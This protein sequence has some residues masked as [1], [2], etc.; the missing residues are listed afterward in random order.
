MLETL[1]F[2]QGAVAKKDFVPALVHFHIE[3]GF[4]KGFNGKLGLCSPID[5]DLTVSPKAVPFIKAIQTC[6]ETV[7]MYM[8]GNGRLGIKSGKF[9][10]FIDC[11]E[12]TFPDIKP[13]GETKITPT[14]ELLPA[15]KKIAPFIAEDASRPWARGILFCNQSAFATNN[16]VLIEYWLGYDFPKPINIPQS[17]IQELIRINKEPSCIQISDTSL[18][19]HFDDKRWLKTQLFSTDWPDPYRI[20]EL[21]SNL[22]DIP[23]GLFEAVEDITPFVNELGAVYLQTNIVSTSLDLDNGATADVDGLPELAIYNNKH[24]LKLKGIAAKA[25][26]ST[27]PKPSLF[28][29][30]KIRGAIIGLRP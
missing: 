25:D 6:K 8:T 27:Y 16:I 21:E 19:F 15:I 1:K 12:E 17:A 13:E 7:S 4:I 10:A 5:L 14:G 11:T 20:F 29:G 18:T 30:D 9:K 3:N 22:Q 26:F 24:L 2:V 28:Q 23:N